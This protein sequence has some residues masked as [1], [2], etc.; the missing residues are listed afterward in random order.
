M[1]SRKEFLQVSSLASVAVLIGWSVLTNESNARIEEELL[2]DKYGTNNP[3]WDHGEGRWG[4][5]QY[6]PQLPIYW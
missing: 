3:L 6:R 1:L 4:C 5:S 2:K